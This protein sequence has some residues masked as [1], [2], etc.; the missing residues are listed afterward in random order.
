MCKTDKALKL[1][2][3]NKDLQSALLAVTTEEVI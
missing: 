2:R 3:I 1:K